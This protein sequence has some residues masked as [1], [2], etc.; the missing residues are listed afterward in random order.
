MILR[1]D[2]AL[3]QDHQSEIKPPKF[4]KSTMASDEWITRNGISG[5]NQTVVGCKVGQTQHC[6]GA[7]ER[8]SWSPIH[9]RREPRS[10]RY[11][12]GEASDLTS[13]SPPSCSLD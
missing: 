7:E 2:I 11:E 9:G 12:T 5:C 13:L 6:L 1:G 8:E 10:Q 4:Y 3:E